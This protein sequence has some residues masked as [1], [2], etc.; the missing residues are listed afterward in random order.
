M[1]IKTDSTEQ[2]Q[3]SSAKYF[4]NL[5]LQLMIIVILHFSGIKLWT[6]ILLVE[7]KRTMI[8]QHILGN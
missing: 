3:N 6:T 1:K 2:K 4:P 8:K 5:I 7:E